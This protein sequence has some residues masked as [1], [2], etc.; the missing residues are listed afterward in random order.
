MIGEQDG[1]QLRE[2]LRRILERREHD[3][4]L[5]DRPREQLDL[6]GEGAL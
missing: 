3:R 5:V 6:I 2:R 1:A 4:P